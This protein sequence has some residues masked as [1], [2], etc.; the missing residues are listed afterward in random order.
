MVLSSILF[1]LIEQRLENILAKK[2]APKVPQWPSYG[3]F[4]RSPET[5]IFWKSAK[6]A[7]MEIFQ[8]SPKK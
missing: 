5:R 2:E 6:G 1:A 8:K 7:P 3:N 4:A